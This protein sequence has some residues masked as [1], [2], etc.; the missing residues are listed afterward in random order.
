VRLEPF[1]RGAGH[2]R[3]LRPGTENVASIV[4][5][6][7]AGH[8]AHELPTAHLEAMADRLY[9]LLMRG[10]P[11]L[12]LNGSRSR[13]LPNTLNLSA[14]KGLGRLWLEAAPTIAASTG[15]ACHAGVDEP[16]AVLTAMGV[17]REQALAAVRLSVGR[18]TTGEEIDHAA[19]ALIRAYE[20]SVGR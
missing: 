20:T 6:G 7:A 13:R 16:S 3:G 9:R 2:E 1:A 4:G 5:L 8:L 14:P 19:V 11:G 17:S 12:T 18:S 10:I 15:S